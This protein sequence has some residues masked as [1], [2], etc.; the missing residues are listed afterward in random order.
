MEKFLALSEDKQ[1]MIRNAALCCFA[2]HGYDKASINDIAVAAGIS[3]ASMFQYF[4]SKQALYI[5]LFQYCTEQM[6]QVYDLEELD[7][8]EDLFDRIWAASVMKVENLEK[9]PYAAAFIAGAAMEQSPEMKKQMENLMDEGTRFVEKLVLR[10]EDTRKFRRPQDARLVF[11]MLM[12]LGKG[13]SLQIEREE[14]TDYTSIMDEFYHILQMLKQ[15]F[16]KEEYL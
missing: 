2:K 3:K 1:V 14:K 15:N 7:K 11:Q 5:Y 6:K 10:V 16:Y 12:L 8:Y 13:L 9:H 4:G